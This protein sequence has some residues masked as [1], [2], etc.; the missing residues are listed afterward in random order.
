MSHSRFQRKV[1][2]LK[3]CLENLIQQLWVQHPEERSRSNE[4]H[5]KVWLRYVQRV[6]YMD[7]VGRRNKKDQI[8][9]PYGKR[10]AL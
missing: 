10:L 4:T 6:T 3:M 9:E 2:H 1:V 5:V 8:K 7:T